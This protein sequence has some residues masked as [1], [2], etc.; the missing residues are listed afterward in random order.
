MVDP[1]VRR[2]GQERG[3]QCNEPGNRVVGELRI[4]HVPLR[5]VHG[6]S[7]VYAPPAT[8]LHHVPEALWIGRLAHETDVDVLIVPLHPV[9]NLD[10]AVTCIFFFVTRDQQA[11]R[12]IRS[13]A[14]KKPRAGGNER[15]NA[16]LHVRRA[17]TV[18][19]S[20]LGDPAKRI[21]V[22]RVHGTRRHNVRMTSEAEIRAARPDSGVQVLDL[23]V[24]TLRTGLPES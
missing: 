8:D 13:P 14:A 24:G 15:S 16:S 10:C 6:Q 1:V 21:L 20:V 9:K 23:R 3:E 5:A 22:P 2:L 17:P 19:D 7:A 4:S 11:D 18:Q 12:A